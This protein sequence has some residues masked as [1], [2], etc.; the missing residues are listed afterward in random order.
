[1]PVKNYRLKWSIDPEKSHPYAGRHFAETAKDH[2]SKSPRPGQTIL[3]LS[4]DHIPVNILLC[5]VPS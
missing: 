4:G 5:D 2:D 3:Q 1:M